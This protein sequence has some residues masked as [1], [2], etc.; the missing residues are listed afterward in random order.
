MATQKKMLATVTRQTHRCPIFGLP[1][2]LRGTNLSIHEEILLSCF[3][4]NFKISEQKVP[5]STIADNV[6]TQIEM[7]YCKASIP[8]LSHARIVKMIKAYHETY[9][10]LRKSYNRDKE[11]KM[12]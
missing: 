8:V 9:N 4:E 12:A 1:K 6:A 5:F 11:K 7:I 2:E 10:M 3:E